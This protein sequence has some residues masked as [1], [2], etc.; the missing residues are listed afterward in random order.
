MVSDLFARPDCKPRRA[1]LTAARRGLRYV[2]GTL[3][4]AAVAGVL[5]LSLGAGGVPGAV[6]AGG[7]LTVDDVTSKAFG[8]H[9]PGLPIGEL[10]HFTIGNRLFN[11]N[12]VTAPASVRSLDGLGPYFNRVSCSACHVRDG[13]GRPPAGP[14]APMM[15]MLVRLSVPGPE[16]TAVPHAIYGEQLSDRAV[17]GL[18]PEGRAALSWEPVDPFVYAD[19]SAVPLRRPRLDFVEMSHGPLGPQAMTS[20]RVANAVFGLGLLEAVPEAHV[21]A[22]ADPHDADGDGVSGRVNRVW[23]HDAQGHALGRFGWKANQPTLRQ[24]AAAAMAGDVGV[25]SEH[26]ADGNYTAAQ[27]QAAALPDG[28]DEQGVE[29]SRKQLDRMTFYLQTLAVP[30]RR[31][32]QD[33]VVQRGEQLFTA[34]GCNACHTPVMRTG[35][36]AAHRVLE[37]QTFAPYTDLLLHDMGPGLADAR[38]DGLASGRE[39]RTAPLWGLGLQERVSGHTFLL[40]DGRARNAEEAVLWHGGEA[41]GARDRFASW[42]AEDRAAVLAFLDSL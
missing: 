9:A 7:G 26:F 18:A 14:E 21:V 12:W 24:Q 40:H 33:P 35:D 5:A 16:D 15:S 20:A 10:R 37:G 29:L 25:T 11:T 27:T 31:R 13:R 6:P 3:L 28:A 32:T 17:E 22:R 23:D 8:Q 38:P 36:T 42:P 4:I 19:G 30:A 41:Q 39:W 1:A 2:P 34:A